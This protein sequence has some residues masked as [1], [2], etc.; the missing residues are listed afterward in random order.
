MLQQP[1]SKATISHTS[2]PS[3]EKLVGPTGRDMEEA[4]AAAEDQKIEEKVS[5]LLRALEGA[6]EDNVSDV[7]RDVLSETDPFT[8]IDCSGPIYTEDFGPLPDCPFPPL[9]MDFIDS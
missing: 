2:L 4:A 9:F 8:D 7:S 1:E 6:W 5:L 3:P